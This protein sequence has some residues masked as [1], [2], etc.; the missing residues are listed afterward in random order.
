MKVLMISLKG[1]GLGICQKI[2]QEGHTV[3][4]FIKNPRFDLCGV[5]LYERIPS[6]R[7][8]MDQADLILADTN[9][10]SSLEGILKQR[11]KPILGFADFPDPEEGTRD[12][13][14]GVNVSVEGWFNGR[15]WI[16]PFVCSFKDTRF[17]MHDLGPDTICMGVVTF[18][19][20]QNKLIEETLLLLTP[21]LKKSG[22]RG[23]LSINRVINDE[24]TWTLKPTYGFTY[25]TTEALME[26]LEEPFADFL[27]EVAQG[28]KKEMNLSSDY[29]I[30][31][32][33][34]IPPW[35]MSEP[36]SGVGR[37]VLGLSKENLRHVYFSDVYKDE[38]GYYCATGSGIILKAT[39]HGRSV[40]EAR[41]RVYRTLDNINIQDK[42]Y[43]LDIGERVDRD[44]EQLKTWGWL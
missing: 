35:P 5:G 1:D 4:A 18:A 43:R 3:Y 29:C 13:V 39:A 42:Q 30:A 31:V 41:R 44:V 2:A 28:S 7:P 34:S 27:F 6:W 11:S 20:D 33:L 24:I 26:G 19:V 14:D 23:P 25:D 15:D 36:I 40:K 10:F 37:T 32:R 22:Y 8:Y 38:E 21:S 17:L 9:G 16:K 12:Y